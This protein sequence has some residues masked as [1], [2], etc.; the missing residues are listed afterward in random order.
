MFC[1]I[2]NSCRILKRECPIGNCFEITTS[3]RCVH[4]VSNTA[5]IRIAFLLS[6]IFDR[7]RVVRPS[8]IWYFV[9]TE[10][11]RLNCTL[12]RSDNAIAKFLLLLTVLHKYVPLHFRKKWQLTLCFEQFM[13]R[14]VLLL[15]GC[16][17]LNCNWFNFYRDHCWH[18]NYV[19][20][21][22]F[23]CNGD[24]FRFFVF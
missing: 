12:Y 8:Q 9:K 3:N 6:K 11:Y 2:L 20:S 19:E 4:L 21:F 10:N 22:S 15:F 17:M 18:A 13:L 16:L 1:I 23:K 7:G 5:E 24:E 14:L